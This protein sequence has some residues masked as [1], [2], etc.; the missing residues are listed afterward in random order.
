M[1]P[2]H[3]GR[4]RQI[5]RARLRVPPEAAGAWALLRHADEHAKGSP[6]FDR[7]MAIVLFDWSVEQAMTTFLQNHNVQCDK[8]W[9]RRAAKW[10][11]RADSLDPEHPDVQWKWKYEQLKT[12]AS[13][14]EAHDLD[15]R[16]L[17]PRRQR[18]VRTYTD[19]LS[20]LHDKRNRLYHPAYRPAR[21]D[22]EFVT[23]EDVEWARSTALWATQV[24][25][26]FDA[27]EALRKRLPVPRWQR[28]TPAGSSQGH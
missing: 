21:A 7:R 24:L 10:V 2:S 25:F 20:W 9:D 26:G 5:T 17:V 12:R 3:P 23:R 6:E 13:D 19:S 16:Y 22:R 27:P 4:T 1:T 8:Y 11:P 14:L 18:I 28:G 15:L